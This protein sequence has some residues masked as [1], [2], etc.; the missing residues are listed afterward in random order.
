MQHTWCSL[1]WSW[2]TACRRC[3]NYIFILDLTPGPNGL[4]KD[5]CKTRGET[6]KSGD[7]VCI[8]LEIWRWQK[9]WCAEEDTM[10]YN[11]A[12]GNFQA[13]FFTPNTHTNT[14]ADSKIHGANMGPTWVLSAP[15]GSHVSPIDLAIWDMTSF[16]ISKYFF[17]LWQ[18]A[19]RWMLRTFYDVTG[20]N[21]SQ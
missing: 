10:C 7:L 12:I 4:G 15:G 17:M 8:I 14:T 21:G 13:Y 9:T 20:V 16:T 6:F 18:R 5:H 1:R 2:S 11:Q 19:I 3:S